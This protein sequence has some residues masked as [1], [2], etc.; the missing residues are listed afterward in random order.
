MLDLDESEAVRRFLSLYYARGLRTW[1]DT[2]WLGVK[3]YKSPLDLWIY[4]ELIHELRPQLIVECGT[5]AGGSALF[6]ASMCD[7]VGCGQVL[8]IDVEA[9]SARP[10][11]PRIEYLTGSSTDDSTINAVKRAARD[12]ADVLVVLDSDHSYQ[13]VLAE[14]RLYADVVT[15]GSY[16]IVEDGIINGNPVLP[17]FGPGPA[18][19]IDQFLSARDDFAVD[20]QRE[21]FF[22]TFNPRG[23]LRKG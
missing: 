9:G 11:H 6:F 3:I 18:E 23:Y 10:T 15:I 13:H 14:M 12:A 2:S 7:L 1:Q 8:T 4:Q 19:A 16:L 21:K 17:E 5:A 22:M 20:T